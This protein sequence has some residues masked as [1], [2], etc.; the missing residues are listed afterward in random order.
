MSHV[1]EIIVQVGVTG[2]ACF[3]A[4]ASVAYHYKKVIWGWIQSIFE[5]IPDDVVATYDKTPTKKV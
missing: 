3:V 5:S 2:T 4:I 1:Y